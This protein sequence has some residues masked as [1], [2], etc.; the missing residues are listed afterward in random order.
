MC[1]K[2]RKLWNSRY[3]PVV[4]WIEHGVMLILELEFYPPKHILYWLPALQ[5]SMI[6][7]F[8]ENSLFLRFQSTVLLTDYACYDQKSI[9]L[10]PYVLQ[11]YISV[12][13]YDGHV[14]TFHKWV[15]EKCKTKLLAFEQAFFECETR[16]SVTFFSPAEKLTSFAH[17]SAFASLFALWA[18]L[19]L[20]V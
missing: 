3:N 8:T 2:Y 15:S 10:P 16:L 5:F 19:E 1:Q 11:D 13:S 6:K 18:S 12:F 17:C 14:C 7:K 9:W 20:S 4:R